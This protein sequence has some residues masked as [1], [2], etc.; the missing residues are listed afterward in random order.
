MTAWLI[1]PAASSTCSTLAVSG[2]RVDAGI[3]FVDGDI[4]RLH[5]TAFTVVPLAVA[6]PLNSEPSL[7]ALASE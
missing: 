1:G 5:V 2:L 6:V 4:G 3:G 7:L